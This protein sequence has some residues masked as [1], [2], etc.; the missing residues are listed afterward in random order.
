MPQLHS[1]LQQLEPIAQ[2]HGL[3]DAA[4]VSTLISE[5]QQIQQQIDASRQR[6]TEL[7]LIADIE[8]RQQQY[9]ACV[10]AGMHHTVLLM[11]SSV[12]Q[13]ICPSVM[14]VLLV[15]VQCHRPVATLEVQQR[16]VKLHL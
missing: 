3:L 11:G 2:R 9:E 10:A 4:N 12:G 5:H 1:T 7:Q 6:A 16:T 14:H 15:A 13:M 8:H